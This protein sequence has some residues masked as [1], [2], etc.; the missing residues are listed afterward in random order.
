[1]TYEQIATI[2]Q[3]AALL[4]FIALFIGVLVYAFWPGNKKRF[5]EAARLPLEKDPEPDPEPEKRDKG[6]KRHGR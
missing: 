5:E 1:M 2:T 3:V 6:A 4:L